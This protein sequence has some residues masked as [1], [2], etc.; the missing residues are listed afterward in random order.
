MNLL[1]LYWLLLK[2]FPCSLSS[3]I[4]RLILINLEWQQCTFLESIHTVS[5]FL[6]ASVCNGMIHTSV[7]ASELF[8]DLKASIRPTGAP[9][10]MRTDEHS[11]QSARF[12]HTG[13][14]H[15]Q[16]KC[17]CC[18]TQLRSVLAN[19]NS[20]WCFEV[21]GGCVHFHTHLWNY[22][23]EPLFSI[24]SLDNL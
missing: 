8:T 14:Y 22:R 5:Y 9:Q 17:V 19:A 23:K 1:L 4:P 12:R 11:A 15:S 16:V 20:C 2:L 6:S 24:A 10:E 13:A 18:P 21:S 7:L 3:W